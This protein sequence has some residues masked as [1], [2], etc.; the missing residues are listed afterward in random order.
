MV[1]CFPGFLSQPLLVLY[2][3]DGD[4]AVKELERLFNK[5]CHV[6][7]VPDQ[8]KRGFI[9][10]IPKRRENKNCRGVTLVPVA[11]KV[12]GKVVIERTQNGVDDVLRKEQAGFRKI[13]STVDQIFTL[14]IEQV[15][16]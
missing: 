3:A 11:S 5:I 4:V 13:K 6:G 7:K 1:Y 2:K 16:E 12:M 14:R 8:W 15:N 9:V 10:K